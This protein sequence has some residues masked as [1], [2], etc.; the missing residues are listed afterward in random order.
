MFQLSA[1]SSAVI[2]GFI[3]PLLVGLLTKSTASV[4]VKV[5][6]NIVL[7]AIVALITNSLTDNGVAI[8]SFQMLSNA[9]LQVAISITTYLGIYKP[10]NASDKLLPGKGIG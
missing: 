3:I 7:S 4:Q 10:L 5:T 8:I 1:Q 6:V 2:V 9:L